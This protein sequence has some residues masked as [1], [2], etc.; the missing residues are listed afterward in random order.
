MIVRVS[1]DSHDNADTY[2]HISTLIRTL[3][4][5]ILPPGFSCRTASGE[6]FFPLK[7]Y[8]LTDFS[9]LR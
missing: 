4:T 9:R 6:K 1:R 3:F 2:G 5:L 8:L 7:I